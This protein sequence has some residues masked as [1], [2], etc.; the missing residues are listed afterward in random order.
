MVIFFYI[1]YLP[2]ISRLTSQTALLHTLTLYLVDSN[3]I[4]VQ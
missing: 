4:Q 1:T 3:E 2:D